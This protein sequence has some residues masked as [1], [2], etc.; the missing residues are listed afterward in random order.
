MRYPRRPHRAAF[1]LVEILIV[2]VILATLTALLLPVVSRAIQTA[3]HARVMSEFDV[4]AVKLEA[5]K[6]KYGDYP[7]SRIILPEDGA[8][9]FAD[10]TM[11]PAVT[12]GQDI[13][14][15]QLSQRTV[16]YLR[17][18]W[19][20]LPISTS[21]TPLFTGS[22][23]WYDFN[24]NGV[25]D[26]PATPG[27]GVI[28]EGQEA[29]CFWLGGIPRNT[30]TT[31]DPELSLGG[32]SRQPFLFPGLG[33]RP[34]P[35]RNNIENGNLAYSGVRDPAFHEFAPS[36]LADADA[37]GFPEFLDS[38]GTLKPIAWFKAEGN[39][40]DPNDCNLP[41]PDTT[42]ATAAVVRAFRVGFLTANGGRL[43]ISP[44]PN[45]YTGS[46]A[47]TGTTTVWLKANSFQF[48][49]AGAD[50]L[51]GAGGRYKPDGK[52]FEEK[53][54]LEPT[55]AGSPVVQNLNSTDTE[56]RQVERDN[57][58]SFAGGPLD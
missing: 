12:G 10:T 25:F 44:G 18:F 1:T 53:M 36:R 56:L 14:Y 20:Q 6:V 48:I 42:G 15:G 55:L 58:A 16:S 51:F 22:G 7:P 47:N 13:T 2:M 4:L 26:K 52:T 3:K 34:H 21:T 9:N 17:R 40:Y 45:P 30:G 8:W 41:E 57:L 50:G 5:F 33:Q 54:P 29:L 11:V 23:T 31:G 46:A 24:G 28:L 37:D 32:F 49:S 35:F 43:A 39:G 27:R 38:L 19:P